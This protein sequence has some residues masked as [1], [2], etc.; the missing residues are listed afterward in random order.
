MT[1]TSACA[2]DGSS[3]ASDGSTASR[4]RR[5]RAYLPRAVRPRQRGRARRRGPDLALRPGLPATV[6]PVP[7]IRMRAHPP[8][9]PVVEVLHERERVP[10]AIP[11]VRRVERTLD[12]DLVAAVAERD[13]EA[14]HHRGAGAHGED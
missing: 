11:G 4:G 1:T 6:E 5:T 8:L 12:D 9:E 7:A 14:E 2:N 3:A 13:R 10:L